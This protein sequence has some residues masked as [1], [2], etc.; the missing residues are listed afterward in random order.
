GRSGAAPAPGAASSRP[1]PA[2]PGARAAR[3]GP[4]IALLLL[5][6]N[7]FVLLLP[8]AALILYRVYDIYLL[9]QTERQL[10]AQSVVVGEAYRDAYLHERG[11]APGEPRPPGTEHERY[12]PGEPLIDHG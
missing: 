9:R 4:S 8:I 12:V 6:V 3:G 5:G 11:L 10:I 1:E 7:V 2:E